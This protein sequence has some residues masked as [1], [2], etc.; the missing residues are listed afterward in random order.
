MPSARVDEAAVAD[1]DGDADVV[2][3][4]RGEG[5]DDD[6]RPDRG[7]VS[8]GE[9]DDGTGV[10]HRIRFPADDPMQMPHWLN[11]APTR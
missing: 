1:D 3:P 8:E 11:V 2:E 6:L 9:G 7:R 10:R 4:A 5:L